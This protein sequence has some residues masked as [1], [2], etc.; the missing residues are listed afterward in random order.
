MA[1]REKE[2]DLVEKIEDVFDDIYAPEA[3]YDEDL[4]QNTPEEQFGILEAQRDDFR[5][6][7]MRALAD[8][9]N[10]R[11]RGERDRREAEKYGGSNSP[12][13]C[14]RFSTT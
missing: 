1:E 3:D 7:F 6:K 11:K 10:S 8:A 9:E 5:D 2:E 14:C 4:A 13:T 12:A